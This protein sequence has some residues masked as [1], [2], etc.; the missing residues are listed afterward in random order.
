MSH[1]RMSAKSVAHES[2]GGTLASIPMPVDP[3]GNAPDCLTLQTVASLQR[4]VRQNQARAGTGEAAQSDR[5]FHQ[6]DMP[7]S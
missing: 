7:R 4:A 3:V 5:R 2:T 6:S 1:Y